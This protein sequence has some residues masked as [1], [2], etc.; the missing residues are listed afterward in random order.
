MTDTK[1]NVP[2]V[3]LSTK[4]S[5]NL[6]KQLNEWF[7]KSVSALFQ[8]VKR[9]FVLGYFIAAGNDADEKQVLKVIKIFSLKRKN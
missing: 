1:L 3:T 6:A 8:G 9:L 2:I 4:D 7:K 5:R